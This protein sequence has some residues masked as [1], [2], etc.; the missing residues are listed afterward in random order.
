MYNEARKESKRTNRIRSLE[1][2]SRWQTERAGKI[3]Q[4]LQAVSPFG[5]DPGSVPSTDMM[6]HNYQ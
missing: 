2:I 1:K 3:V 4:W 5:E 6:A